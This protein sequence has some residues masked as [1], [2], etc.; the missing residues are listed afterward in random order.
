MAAPTL[1]RRKMQLATLA[2]A[3]RQRRQARVARLSAAGG[4]PLA[5]RFL[6]LQPDAVLLQWPPHGTGTIAASG[7]A[8]EVRFQDAG[9]VLGFRTTTRGRVQCARDMG[10]AIQAWKLA[11][12]LC[13]EPRQPR[14]HIR[15]TTSAAAPLAVCCTSVTNL[16]HSLTARLHDLSTGGLRIRAPQHEAQWAQPGEVIWTSIA[17]P[18]GSGNVEFVARVLHARAGQPDGTVLLGCRFCPR[19]DSTVHDRQLA[20]LRQF[21]VPSPRSRQEGG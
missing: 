4:G 2:A 17:L 10:G 11:L 13:V 1:T 5:L 20:Q 19:D 15:A 3:C 12:P 21:L 16:G 7:A 9:R 8:V 18:D 14:Q 6:A